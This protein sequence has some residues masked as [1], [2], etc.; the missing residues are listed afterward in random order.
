MYIYT[1]AGLLFRVTMHDNYLRN[2]SR[3]K[4]KHSRQRRKLLL[5]EQT[6]LHSLNKTVY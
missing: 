3:S 4:F 5:Q 6:N 2:G 1:F